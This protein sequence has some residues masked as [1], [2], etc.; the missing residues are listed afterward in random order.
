[1]AWMDIVINLKP[2]LS[3]CKPEIN[4]SKLTKGVLTMTKMCVFFFVAES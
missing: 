4:F 1:M 3:E 2:Y